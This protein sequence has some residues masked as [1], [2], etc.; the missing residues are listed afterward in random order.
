M[1]ASL[2]LLRIEIRR[3]I[4]LWLFPF[5]IILVLYSTAE[6]LP[7]SIWL[8]PQTSLSIRDTML[9]VGPLAAGLGAWSADRNRRRG[10]EEL[11]VSTPRTATI[12]ELGNWGATAAWINLGYAVAAVAML[13]IAYLKGSSGTLILWPVVV[14]LFA[15][16]ASSASGYAAGCYLPSRITAPIVAVAFYWAQGIA[17]YNLWNNP[18]SYLSPVTELEYSVFW[19]VLP[20]IFAEQSMWLVGVTGVSLAAVILRGKASPKAA[21]IALLGATIVAGIGAATLL[22]TPVQ[23]T[24]DQKQEARI[25][26][27][28]VCDRKGT[29]PVCVHPAYQAALPKAATAI[30][31]IAGPLT[32]LPGGPK[33]AE[34]ESNGEVVLERNGTLSFYLSD[35][36]IG[37]DNFSS[38]LAWA[39]VKDSGS[40]RGEKETPLLNE[41]Q[42]AIAGWLLQRSDIDVSS[43]NYATARGADTETT[44]KARE[45]FA[46]LPTDERKSWLRANYIKLRAGSISLE[47]LP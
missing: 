33:R 44:A 8:W 3:N 15:V 41:A 2:K 30:E 21:W 14:G 39:L 9:L 37:N 16:M 43:L 22:G 6:T 42:S 35:S 29:V 19:G 23:V 31:A 1:S 34:Q 26:Y 13:L 5:V 17:A 24:Q 25:A 36:N 7:R 12:R 38:E 47:D 11:L 28:P 45:R 4:G 10:I 32:D 20:D 40:S 18:A 27:E 46:R